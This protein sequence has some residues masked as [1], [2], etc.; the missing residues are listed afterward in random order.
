MYIREVLSISNILENLILM[1]EF[2]IQTNWYIAFAMSLVTNLIIYF[3]AAYLINLLTEKITRH[4]RLGKYIDNRPLKR[5]QKTNEIKYGIF[6]C[7]IF[8]L[9]SLLARE[10]FVGVIPSSI[11][12][13]LSEVLVFTL[14][15]ETYS[16]FVHRLLHTKK[17]RKPHSVHHYSVRTTPWSAYSVHPI[18]ALLIGMSAP[19]FMLIFPV[20]LSVIFSFHILGVVFTLLIHSNLKLNGDNIFCQLFNRYTESHAAHHS[21]GNVNFGFINSFWDL[22]FKTKYIESKELY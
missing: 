22:C 8:S 12:Q 14:F 5:G 2:W 16:Y 20:H 13:L 7:A 6:A 11:T 10:L 17:F 18:E 1:F 9:V 19:L 4:N 21:V 3:V 15:Y